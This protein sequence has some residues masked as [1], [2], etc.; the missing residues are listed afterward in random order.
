MN[1]DLF[2]L[3]TAA[4]GRDLLS[5][6]LQIDPMNRITVD[7]A[8]RHPYVSVWFDDSEVNAVRVEAYKVSLN[9]QYSHN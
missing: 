4:Y 7:Q 8:L 5:K 1:I 2:L 9:H 3:I 6:M